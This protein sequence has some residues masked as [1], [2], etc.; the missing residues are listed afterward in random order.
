MAATR[1]RHFIG[2]RGRLV[3]SL[4]FLVVISMWLLGLAFMQLT[5]SAFISQFNSRARVLASAVQN[6]IAA[7]SIRTS[8]P[9]M[10]ASRPS[11][12]LDSLLRSLAADPEVETIEISDG[13]GRLFARTGVSARTAVPGRAAGGRGKGPDFLDVSLPLSFGQG[14]TG[15]LRVLFSLQNLGRQLGIS[16]LRIVIQLAIT[17]LVLIVFI[18]ILVSLSILTPIRRLLSATERVGTG[19]WSGVVEVGGRDEFGD[20]ALSF[21]TMLLH[22]RKSEESNR[23]QLESLRLAHADLQAKETQLVES[24]KMAAVGRV[25]AGVAHEVG[26]PLGSVTGYLAMLRDEK[27]SPEEWREYLERTDRELGRINRIMLDLLNYARPPRLEWTDI[28]LNALL[29]DV[30]LMLSAQPEF[31]LSTMT[32]RLEED[33]PPVRGDLHR[34]R[35]MLVNISLNAAQAMPEGGEIFLESFRPSVPGKT[36][37]I[38]V[39]DHGPGIA[40]DDLP[41]IFEPFF[42]SRKSGRGSGLGLALCRQIAFSMGISIDVDSAVGEGSIFTVLFPAP[43]DKSKESTSDG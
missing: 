5:K 41:H 6:V 21:N 7:E 11:P 1:R 19:D 10:T 12:L 15:S 23:R 31:S 3:V 14:E 27:L 20:L 4:L 40:A 8:R 16:Q 29:R 34:V 9:A 32:A 26:N 38:R 13:Q 33:L 36:A 35:Q 28:D 39:Q 24:E 22:L 30:R 25:A 43:T 42:T 37:G 17:V 18:N 2:V